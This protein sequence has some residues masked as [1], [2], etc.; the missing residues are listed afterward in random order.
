M[1]QPYVSRH[2]LNEAIELI[3]AGEA[4][5]AEVFCRD[6]IDRNPRVRFMIEGRPYRRTGSCGRLIEF[7]YSPRGGW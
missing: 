1:S 3:K 7:D 2:P 5:K 4:D 6:A